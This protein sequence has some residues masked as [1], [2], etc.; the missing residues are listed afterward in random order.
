MKTAILA[1][2]LLLATT[3]YAGPPKKYKIEGTLFKG[4]D[5]EVPMKRTVVFDEKNGK[6][7]ILNQGE[8]ESYGKI[9]KQSVVLD[10]VNKKLTFRTAYSL[11]F[12]PDGG[13]WEKLKACYDKILGI[14]YK[15]QKYDL[16]PSTGAL[17]DTTKGSKF[18]AKYKVAI[19]ETYHDL[20]I[21]LNTNDEKQGYQKNIWPKDGDISFDDK[22]ISFKAILKSGGASLEFKP[23]DKKVAEKI[24]KELSKYKELQNKYATELKKYSASYQESY[25][26][27]Q[28]IEDYEEEE[29][30]YYD[31]RYHGN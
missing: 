10:K 11:E 1:A 25:N 26:V 27:Y 17:Y 22:G 4:T 13:K 28:R 15:P 3:C 30:G 21:T 12:E 24:K 2:L 18:D 31:N 7:T 6:L 5:R 23:L 14:G 29:E 16:I 19:G 8:L 20:K 9:E